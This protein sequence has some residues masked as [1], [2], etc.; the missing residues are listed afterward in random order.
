MT[1]DEILASKTVEQLRAGIS[2]ART[3]IAFIESL[4][5]MD[6]EDDW[7][8]PFP[9]SKGFETWVNNFG[10]REKQL[11]GLGIRD[12]EKE[13]ARRGRDLGSRQFSLSSDF[14]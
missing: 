8:G 7:D 14:E 6:P 13:L 2:K 9:P 5:G 3:R 1:A 4:E 10:S 12:G 11:L